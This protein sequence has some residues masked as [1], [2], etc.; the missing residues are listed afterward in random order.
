M[1]KNKDLVYVS[2][3]WNVGTGM[4]VKE[5]D[6]IVTTI[7]VVGFSK[8]VSIKHPKFGKVLS[9]VIFVDY[10]NG[11]V[12]IRMPESV[13]SSIDILNFELAVITQPVKLY[14]TNYYNKII[15]NSAEI[16]DVSHNYNNF[17]HLRIKIKD[18]KKLSGS[19]ILNNR[20]EFVGITKY[21]ENED[22]YL[23]LPSKYILKSMEE[24]S[25]VGQEAVRCPNCGNVV[26]KQKIFDYICPDCTGQ[27]KFEILNDISPVLSDVEKNIE[28]SLAK[29]GYDLNFSRLGKKF[30]EIKQ[31][32][33]TIFIKYDQKKN[34]IVAFSRLLVLKTENLKE[35][36]KYLLIE[37]KKLGMLSFSIQENE[38]FLSAPYIFDDDFD[39]IFAKNIFKDLFEKADYYDDILINMN[40]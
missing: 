13:E 14:R 18:A 8:K 3:A 17:N 10:S 27:I 15:A 37:N 31:G 24:F 30:W 6:F 39:E 34:F 33:A 29:M 32:S 1:I 26:K 38:V 25:N 12:F 2:S 9:D 40:S 20:D 36:Y 22:L 21:I 4:I 23:G 35:I 5:Y 28:K 19:I 16:I 11:L 7:Q